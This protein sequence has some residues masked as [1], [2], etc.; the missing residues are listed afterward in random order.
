M[1]EKTLEIT[2]LRFSYGARPILE[3]VSFSTYPGDLIALLGPNGVGK[4]TLLRCIL[5]FLK[6]YQGRVIVAGRDVRGLTARA[7]ARLVA[8]IPQSSA[9][10]FDYTVLELVLM[11]KASQMKMLATPGRKEEAEARAV[12]DELG[13]DHLRHRGCGQISGGEYQLV[14]LARA[15]LQRA[16]ILLMD[17]P[18]ANLDYGNQ[19]RVMERIARLSRRDFT[20]MLSTHDPNQALLHANRAIIVQKGRVSAD[21]R[22]DDVMTAETLSG[23]FG[24]D[25]RRMHVNDAGRVYPICIPAGLSPRLDSKEKNEERKEVLV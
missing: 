18:T 4:S 5:G 21:G 14:L 19:Y 13:I 15:L 1:A 12:L 22:P 17:E 6:S 11:G 8:Y 16:R 24:I 25:V 9:Q 10:V 7:L 20:V 3:G 23:M 2:D